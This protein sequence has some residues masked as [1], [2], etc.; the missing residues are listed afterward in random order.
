MIST[1]WISEAIAPLP[2]IATEKEAATVLRA[3][4]RTVRR[5]IVSGRLTA[6]RATE[7]DR[8]KVL[9]PRAAIE[10][11]LRAAAGEP[12]IH[13]R[14]KVAR[15]ARKGTRARVA[16]TH[17]PRSHLSALSPCL[18]RSWTLNA[19]PTGAG[20][21]GMRSLSTQIQRSNVRT[22]VVGARNAVKKLNAIAPMMNPFVL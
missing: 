15:P 2:P 6:T 9:V 14:S 16:V 1:D 4:L 17:T 18:S 11:Y 3:S 5:L 8:S 21:F 19:P 22:A 13:K 20:R 10:A 12:E 7:R